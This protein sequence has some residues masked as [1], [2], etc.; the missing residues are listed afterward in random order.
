MLLPKATS[1]RQEARWALAPWAA[2][3][4][5]AER[6]ALREEEAAPQAGWVCNGVGLRCK[7]ELCSNAPLHQL[8]SARGRTQS[9]AHLRF[10]ARRRRWPPP[11]PPRSAA[12]RRRWRT[13]PQHPPG[14]T[15]PAGAGC[16]C[17]ARRWAPFAAARG[18]RRAARSLPAVS[19]VRIHQGMRWLLCTASTATPALLKHPASRPLPSTDPVLR[20]VQ[21]IHV[22]AI[23][24]QSGAGPGGLGRPWRLLALPPKQR[25][26][27]L[28]GRRRRHGRELA[29][30]VGG[31]A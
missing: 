15:W 25:T 7:G 13:C 4:S 23:L 2:V 14:K 9:C 24:R 31:S 29:D 30:S 27:R 11:A 28:R 26:P 5:S 18:R 12:G 10:P 21:R 22:H 3:A 6:S 1:A 16:W 20:A 8:L 19:S 17:S